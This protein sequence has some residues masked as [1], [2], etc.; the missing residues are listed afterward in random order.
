M[1]AVVELAGVGRTFAGSPPVEAVRDADLVVEEG[2]YVAIVGPSGSGKSTLLHILGCLDTPTSGSYRLR[3]IDVG[4]LSDGD[5][6]SL[7]GAE[8]GFVFQAFHL[9][10]Y[11]SVIENVMT[12][13]VYNRTPRRVRRERSRQALERVG[14]SHRLDFTPRQLSGG[15][16]QRVAVARAIAAQP[17]LLLCDEPT[18][19]LDTR[20]TSAIL[21]LFDELRTDGLT[22]MVITH[23]ER[24]SQRAERRIEMIDGFLGEA[25]S[26]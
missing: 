25:E 7:R 26:S 1:S 9:L 2:G 18:G 13:L 23:E 6:T 22:L 3:G 21:D 10:P 15:E 17:S 14:L 12:G 4:G 8:V 16:R 24:V 19:N 20:T 11:R 5:R